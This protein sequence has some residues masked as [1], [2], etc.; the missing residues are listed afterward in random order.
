MIKHDTTYRT[1]YAWMWVVV[2]GAFAIFMAANT[3]VAE[4][5]DTITQTTE[6]PYS[7]T[8]VEDNT[9]EY[10]KT[11]VRKPGYP[12]KRTLTYKVRKKGSSEISRELV[13]D[14]VTTE[15]TT[16]VIAKG[17]KV[18]WHCKDT[19][20]YDQNAYNDNYCW[21]SYG[22]GRY[23][24]DSEAVAIDPTYMPGKSGA[25]YYNNK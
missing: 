19:T 20:S 3:S 9:L 22:E 1:L 10:G 24:P 21:N 2:V 15:P 4:R 6:V 13:R 11:V 18:V 17:T 7:T 25:L 5:M 8:Y 12:G 16:E 23:V 14:K